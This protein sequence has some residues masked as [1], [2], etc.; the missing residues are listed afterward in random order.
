MG[1]IVIIVV[2]LLWE[3]YFEG[4]VVIEGFLEYELILRFEDVEECWY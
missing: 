1:V 3:N 4:L 2:V